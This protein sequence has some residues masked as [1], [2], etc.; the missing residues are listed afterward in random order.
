MASE[1]ENLKWLI[2]H[3]PEIH[4]VDID[5]RAFFLRQ[6]TVAD[7][8]AFDTKVA[9][10]EGGPTQMRSPM[11]QSVLCD[12]GG[13][14][15]GSAMDFDRLPAELVEPLVNKAAELFGISDPPTEGGTN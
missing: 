5:G 15:I 8:D 6:P 2:Q 1:L 13:Q 11:L 7:R 10:M 12:E 9:G 3:K 4:Q 14:L